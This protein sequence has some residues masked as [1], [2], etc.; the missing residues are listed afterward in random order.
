ML[1]NSLPNKHTLSKIKVYSLWGDYFV[2]VIVLATTHKYICPNDTSF[3]FIQTISCLCS[4]M[5]NGLNWEKPISIPN[6]MI[7]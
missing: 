6:S 3:Y 1:Y 5:E 4:F 7:S 2:D